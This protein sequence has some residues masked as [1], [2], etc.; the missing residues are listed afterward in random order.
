MEELMDYRLYE[1][2]QDAL[3]GRIDV[4][5]MLMR[6]ETKEIALE[7]LE[8]AYVI[9]EELI[10]SVT[11]LKD[12]LQEA[13]RE[14]DREARHTERLQWR[15]SSRRSAQRQRVGLDVMHLL[16]LDSIPSLQILAPC[17]SCFLTVPGSPD[18]PHQHREQEHDDKDAAAHRNPCPLAAAE[19]FAVATQRER[20]VHKDKELHCL[21][22]AHS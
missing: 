21:D 3:Q 14:V 16:L 2:L 19:C 9:Y 11:A 6:N 13:A 18:L 20:A 17:A 15:A 10:N 4:V 22:K 7:K 12:R 8:A 5:N 1:E